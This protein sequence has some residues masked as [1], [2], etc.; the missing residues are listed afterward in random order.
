M[1]LHHAARSRQE[2]AFGSQLLRDYPGGIALYCSADGEHMD[3][4]RILDAAPDDAVFYVCGPAR[5]IDA[6]RRVSASSGIATERLRVERLM[7]G[8]D[9]P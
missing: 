5:L 4:G 9:G 2:L 7:A 6:V 8:I 3:V 1:Q